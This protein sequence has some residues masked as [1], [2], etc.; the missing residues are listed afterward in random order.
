[1]TILKGDGFE[2]ADGREIASRDCGKKVLD[3]I[4]VIGTVSLL[5]I[6]RHRDGTVMGRIRGRGV[7]L[8]RGVMGNV[9]D[10]RT[11]DRRG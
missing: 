11:R 5:P 3:V 7:L 1:M 10:L 8:E 6:L 4:L 9:L 2:E